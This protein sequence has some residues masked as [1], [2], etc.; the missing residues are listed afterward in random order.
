MDQWSEGPCH[1][2]VVTLRRRLSHGYR[3]LAGTSPPLEWLASVTTADS[4]E[5]RRKSSAEGG[6]NRHQSQRLRIAGSISAITLS[7]APAL[8]GQSR[9]V[10]RNIQEIK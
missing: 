3:A 4:T 1:E 2:V 7:C 8:L 10:K 9:G 5:G 6:S